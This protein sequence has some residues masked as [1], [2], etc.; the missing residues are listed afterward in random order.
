VE[1]NDEQIQFNALIK[2]SNL[3]LKKKLKGKT[4]FGNANEK[5]IGTLK[6][7]RLLFDLY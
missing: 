1:E 2:I 6:D 5:F 7:P 4:A 3:F